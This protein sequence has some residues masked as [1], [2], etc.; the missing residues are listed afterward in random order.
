VLYP[1]LDP[2][3]WNEILRVKISQN[4]VDSLFNQ[5]WSRGSRL[6]VLAEKWVIKK[7]RGRLDRFQSPVDQRVAS[8]FA[9]CSKFIRNIFHWWNNLNRYVEFV[10]KAVK[11]S[12]DQ[13][14]S[15]MVTLVLLHQILYEVQF[16][17]F[18]VLES[19]QQYSTTRTNQSCGSGTRL[20]LPGEDNGTH[21]TFAKDLELIVLRSATKFD[22]NSVEDIAQCLEQFLT[23]FWK[24]FDKLKPQEVVTQII[25]L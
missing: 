1:F 23:K 14:R 12:T 16:L 2:T 9:F 25:L 20:P 17:R 3:L 6:M 10:L 18:R 8:A 24:I 15:G 22:F 4:R 11:R 7:A 21:R 19:V 13:Q 5:L